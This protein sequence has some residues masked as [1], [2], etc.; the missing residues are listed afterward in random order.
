M[1]IH[2]FLVHGETPDGKAVGFRV[3]HS[4]EAHAFPEVRQFAEDAATDALKRAAPDVQN[5]VSGWTEEEFPD[6]VDTDP[7]DMS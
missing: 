5:V 2:T 6:G 4:P 7:Q 1:K 3:S